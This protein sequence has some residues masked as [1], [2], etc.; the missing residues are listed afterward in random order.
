[1]KYD[2]LKP[3]QQEWIQKFYEG[4]QNEEI[5]LATFDPAAVNGVRDA[6]TRSYIRYMSSK[7]CDMEWG[8]AWIVKDKSRVAT[9]GR[10]GVYMIP[11]LQEY[12][13][14]QDAEKHDEA[15]RDFEQDRAEMSMS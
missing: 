14:L 13:D 9:D 12:A 15:V 7:Y 4:L 5:E 8:P 10:I 2:D 6:Y 3:R 1:M 11:E